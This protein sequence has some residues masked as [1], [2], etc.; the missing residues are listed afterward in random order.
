MK[1]KDTLNVSVKADELLNIEY[2]G[3]KRPEWLHG[4]ML[5]D[6][7]KSQ[8]FNIRRFE[9]EC[10]SKF[11]EKI[12]GAD[13]E[14]INLKHYLETF[15]TGLKEINF[16][17]KFNSSFDCIDIE[18]EFEVDDDMEFIKELDGEMDVLEDEG[19]FEY[20]HEIELKI[21]ELI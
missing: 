13:F 5:H 18:A 6:W 17:S 1:I 16:T 11:V 8:S 7:N 19:Y 12:N 4:A 15:I 14:I 20:R 21:E 10:R 9:E 3:E 2:K